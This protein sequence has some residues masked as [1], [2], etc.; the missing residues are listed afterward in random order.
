MMPTPRLSCPSRDTVWHQWVVALCL[1]LACAPAYAQ[2]FEAFGWLCGAIALR[3]GG[4]VKGDGRG[5][6]V[7]FRHVEPLRQAQ[8]R[9]IF[10]A[11][12]WRIT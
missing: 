9:D 3:Q 5:G 1:A 12:S 7:Y 4:G 2:A 11:S 8:E 6:A 10:P